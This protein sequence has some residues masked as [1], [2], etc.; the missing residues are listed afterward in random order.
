MTDREYLYSPFDEFERLQQ[1]LTTKY[2]LLNPSR[3]E[4]TKDEFDI[5]CSFDNDI[6]QRQPVSVALLWLLI[7]FSWQSNITQLERRLTQLRTIAMSDPSLKT[8]RPI[9]QLRQYV[10]DLQDAL[11]DTKDQI[12][13]EDN[14]AFNVLQ[15]TAG[16]KLET[17]D[18]IFDTLSKHASAL[19]QTA[20]NEIQLVIGSVAIQVPRSIHFPCDL[21]ADSAQDSDT[22]KRQGRRATQLTLLAA[23]YLPL[24]LVTGIFGMN[25]KEFDNVK[26]SF[27]LCIEAFFAVIAVTLVF[28]GLYLY[29]PLVFHPVKQL[30]LQFVV[31]RTPFRQIYWML[32]D[33]ERLRKRRSRE[34]DLEQGFD[35]DV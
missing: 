16:H 6:L 19:S 2:S 27:V 23:F 29:L 13:E 28:Y 9:P 11:R 33:L 4:S 30:I 12:E 25:I 14:D 26:P 31:P 15:S 17:L 34:R 21:K 10:A 22:M 1:L 35:K 7:A 3:A 5:L 18:N 20:S 24:T 32:D 8:F